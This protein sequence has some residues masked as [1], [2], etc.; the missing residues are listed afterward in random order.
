MLMMLDRDGLFL[1]QAH[2]AL[3][4]VETVKDRLA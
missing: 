4:F 3:G 2:D 1:V